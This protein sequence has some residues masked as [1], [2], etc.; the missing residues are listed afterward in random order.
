MATEI[1]RKFLVTSDAWQEE[2]IGPGLRLRQG[3]LHAGS[4]VIRIRQAGDAAFLTI[5]GPGLLARAEF[6][7]PIPPEDAAAMLATLCPPPII[8]KTRTR[9][10]DGWE[11]DVFAGHLAGLVLA[12]IELADA[13]QPF[14]RPAWLG[15]EVT[16]DPRYQNNALAR[17]AGP[18][19]P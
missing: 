13:D 5:K 1:E 15:R 19:T 4:P 8:E 11:V 17:A 18:P 14:P 16:G 7:Y 2:A 10:R 6:E 9:L 3:Y 12:E